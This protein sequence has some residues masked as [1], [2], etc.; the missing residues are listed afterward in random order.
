MRRP[1]RLLQ[2]V[3]AAL[4]ACQSAGGRGA[5]AGGPAASRVRYEGGPVVPGADLH[6][7]AVVRRVCSAQLVEPIS[8]APATSP[9]PVAL[10][11]TFL[12][13]VGSDVAFFF[14]PPESP[15]ARHALVSAT[16]S[17][18][19][20]VT[21]AL[22][23]RSGDSAFDAAALAAVRA[24]A[25][26]RDQLSLKGTSAQ[27]LSLAV[28]FGGAGVP[29]RER[30]ECPAAPLADNPAPHYPLEL[31]QR[32]DRGV[33]V[34][35]FVVDT[36]GLVQPETFA[37]VSSTHEYFTREV[38][39]LLPALRFVPAEVF[40]RKVPQITEQR[41]AFETDQRNPHQ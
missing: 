41:F 23:D 18:G 34:A 28:E 9:P 29:R 20:P 7:A 19:A 37:V 26:G 40:G 39:S 36:L 4:A 10:S 25:L 3:L 33:V 17:T 8:V 21:L 1:S 24:S 30:V 35:R 11:E 22:R 32:G 31:R 27:S 15:R 13:S 16:L 5:S 12:A 2:I 14:V 38:R 6:S